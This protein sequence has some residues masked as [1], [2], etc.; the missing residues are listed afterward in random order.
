MPTPLR[1][2]EFSRVVHLESL[3]ELVFTVRKGLQSSLRPW[4]GPAGLTQ[5]NMETSPCRLLPAPSFILACDFR[6]VEGSTLILHY[7]ILYIYKIYNFIHADS[8]YN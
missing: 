7:T 3:S 4:P 6:K 8:V 5:E 1:S 2:K